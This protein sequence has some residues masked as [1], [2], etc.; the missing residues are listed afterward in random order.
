MLENYLCCCCKFIPWQT[1]CYEIHVREG[2]SRQWCSYNCFQYMAAHTPPQRRQHPLHHWVPRSPPCVHTVTH[3]MT[4]RMFGPHFLAPHISHP[5][6]LLYWHNPHTGCRK[7][8]SRHRISSSLSLRPRA[9]RV[10]GPRGTYSFPGG[11]CSPVIT[12]SGLR[13]YHSDWR[14]CSRTIVN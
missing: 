5:A 14:L 6:S 4:G 1:L 11:R 2:K 10:S 3:L 9:G 12:G 13:T 8:H 7:K